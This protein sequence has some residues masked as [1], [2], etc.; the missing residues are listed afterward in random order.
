MK[1][2]KEPKNAP[3]GEG[4]QVRNLAACRG[5]GKPSIQES[6]WTRRGYKVESLKAPGGYWF[7]GGYPLYKGK[8]FIARCI[9]LMA[10]AREV[11]GWE[12][13]L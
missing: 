10:K 12:G 9:Q 13:R 6:N 2:F 3:E 1:P 5:G 11:N 4:F 8:A 7:G